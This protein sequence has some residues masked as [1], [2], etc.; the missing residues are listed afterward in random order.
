M[1][2]MLGWGIAAA[3]LL[4]LVPSSL[5]ASLSRQELQVLGT[6]LTFIQP[7]PAGD[8]TLAVVYSAANSASRQDADAIMAEI[9]GRLNVSGAVLTPRLVEA[10]ALASTDFS[11][12]IVAAGANSDVVRDAVRAH[13]VLCV[14][15]DQAAVQDG[16]CM[17][18]VRPGPHVE[19]FLNYQAAR[20]AGVGVATAF[21]MM[22]REL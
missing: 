11:L 10:G 18:A 4:E 9:G 2:R 21:R 22:V 5:A 20:Q 8:G 19:I 16:D 1:A 14:T 12:V 13:H 17:M 7:K 3:A 15:A 6:A